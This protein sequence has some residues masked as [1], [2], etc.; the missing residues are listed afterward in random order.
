[1][2]EIILI[3]AFT[4]DVERQDNL[5]DLVKSLKDLNYRVCLITHTSTPQDIID[6]CDYF[7]FD[8]E[9]EILYDPNIKYHF[10]FY[11][12][13][14]SIRFKD[15]TS[16]ATHM[17]PVFRMYLGGLAYLK[18]MGEEVVHMIEYDTI[19]KNKNLWN[20]NLEILKEKDAVFYSFPR[21]YEDNG[22]KCVYSFQSIKLTN[23]PYELLNYNKTQL[24]NQYSNYFNEGKFPIFE[25]MIYDNIWSKLNFNLNVLSSEKD[26]EES[27]I[28]NLIRVGTTS[29]TPTV[30]KTNINYYG[31]K[32]HFFHFND[33]SKTNNFSIIINK[34]NILNLEI[35]PDYWNWIPLDYNEINH[36]QI[37][38]NN[39]L[40]K[41]LDLT[42]EEGRDWIFKHS[43]ANISHSQES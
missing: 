2:K 36:I 31:D 22:L 12:N 29:D 17:L 19:V 43:Y 34:T 21:F 25:R 16:M 41:E 3:S 37:Y 38:K 39:I 13:D 11:A 42:T 4:P 5:R 40:L 28:T 6:K 9:N 14:V 27:F 10:Y 15:Y 23:I 32:F 24:I 20:N 18:S 1:M 35:Q 7:I 26:L 33:S 30:E 8:K